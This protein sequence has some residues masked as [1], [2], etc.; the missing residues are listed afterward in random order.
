V[1]C[2]YEFKF[3]LEHR[4]GHLEWENGS[5]RTF[6]VPKTAAEMLVEGAWGSTQVRGMAVVLAGV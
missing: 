4:S 1:L 3:L 2:R 6:T 5:N